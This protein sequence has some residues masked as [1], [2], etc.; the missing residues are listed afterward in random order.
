MTAIAVDPRPQP[1]ADIW[2]PSIDGVGAVSKR[3]LTKLWHHYNEKRGYFEM[4]IL[5][6]SKMTP[7]ENRRKK[8]SGVP[9]IILTDDV[10][11]ALNSHL[12]RA[13]ATVPLK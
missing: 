12:S 7:L 8:I 9:A 13:Q 1:E 10:S 3:L 11:C 6:L 4:V 2:S 5:E